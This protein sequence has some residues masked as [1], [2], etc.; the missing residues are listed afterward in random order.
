MK[1]KLLICI[2][3]LTSFG[4][5]AQKTI[6]NPE[7]GLSI[8]PGS[9]TKIE[10]LNSETILH[11]HLNTT[12]NTKIFIPTGSYIQD[13]EST[14]K[15]YITK[16]EGINMSKWE[17]IP[18]SG[19]IEYALH[20]P[21]I[22]E[23][24]K[25]IEFG[26]ANEG[27]SWYVYDIVITPNENSIT[28][29]KI[30]GN[31]F[32]TDGS[33]LLQYSFNSNNAIIHNSIWNYQTVKSKKN[34]YTI[35]LEKDG[36]EKIIKAKLNKEGLLS[37]KEDSSKKGIYSKTTQN[38]VNYNPKNNEGLKAPN[39]KLGTAIYSGI[40]KNYTS[41]IGIKTGM[42]YVNN[43]FT[44][45]QEP[46]LIKIAE[47]GTFS[48]ELPITYPQFVLSRVFNNN[49]SI[50]ISP[51]KE[52]FHIIDGNQHFFTGDLAQ[53]NTDLE[54]MRTIRINGIDQKTRENI[55][56]IK[57]EDFKAIY[58]KQHDE[59]LKQMEEL[60]KETFISKKALELKKLALEYRTLTQMLSYDMYS[61]SAKRNL[62][63][64]ELKDLPDYRIDKNYLADITPK[65]LNNEKAV[66][67]EGYSSFINYLTYLDIFNNNTSTTVTTNDLLKYL[68]EQ[69][70]NIPQEQI[71]AVK[72]S[73]LLNTP[74]KQK[75]EEG[76]NKKYGQRLS[77]FYKE[78]L[79]AIQ[80]IQKEKPNED[81]FLILKRQLKK[82]GKLSPV[83]EEML[84]A[85]DN[86]TTPEEKAIQKTFQEKY[87]KALSEFYTKYSDKFNTISTKRYYE[88]KKDK[89]KEILD[90]D[91]SLVLDIYTLQIYTTQLTSDLT[92][93]TNSELK[94]IKKEIT[95]TA[96]ANYIDIANN[97]TIAT[98]EANKTK[99]GYN[100]NKVEKTEGD[101]LFESMIAKF[102][103]KVIYVDFWATWC[104]PCRSG[105]KRIAPLKEEMK[106]EDVV[107]LYISAPSSPE[108]TW[109]NAIPDIKGEHYRVTQDEWNYLTDK[110]NIRGIPHYALVNKKGELVNPKF[111]HRSNTEIK[112]IL[113]EEL[114]K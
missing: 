47:N 32:K 80:K 55:L 102:K 103:G 95:N 53:V 22:K 41:R 54:K 9:I 107:F 30:L 114:K 10:I 15:L 18:E 89:M 97:K 46:H 108:K 57:P 73:E 64:E 27:G 26:E 59:A 38:N 14:D 50:F 99:T 101:E 36:T 56:Q 37:I 29:R 42:V 74:E 8:L 92:P 88:A 34:K 86:K 17:E 96:V 83:D 105:I 7:Y 24:V 43:A 90:L 13:L 78:N 35:I 111:G 100:V 20:F 70:V 23:N 106:D 75:R 44:G 48:V 45:E 40:I 110:F 60:R 98:I 51:G 61:R 39:F 112:K 94:N 19:I 62:K 33:E 2:I 63:P 58:T 77:A 79:A 66:M 76:F 72:A 71:D 109:K 87:G 67:A 93:Y 82:A 31:W 5:F 4:I 16:A 65:I 68:Q 81:I 3:F 12:P 69:N 11:F 84:I 25:T 49:Q 91:T 21:K 6:E 28:P 52:T 85:M 104:G 1:K 113:E